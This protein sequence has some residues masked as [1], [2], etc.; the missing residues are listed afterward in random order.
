[1]DEIGNIK[2]KIYIRDINYS[3]IIKKIFSFLSEKQLLNMKMYNKLFQN[4]L[5]VDIKDYQKIKGKK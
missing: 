4:L 2:N 3:F 5:L 1:M